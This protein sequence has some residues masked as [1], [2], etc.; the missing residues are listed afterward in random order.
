MAAA[1]IDIKPVISLASVGVSASRR[2]TAYGE[3]TVFGAQLSILFFGLG[4]SGHAYWAGESL[5]SLGFLIGNVTQKLQQAMIFKFKV[6]SR[7][8][9]FLR[10]KVYTDRDDNNYSYD[11][12][13]YDKQMKNI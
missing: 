8:Q 6:M 4:S 10:I 9:E 5:D 3:D 2:F 1:N 13:R 7:Y 12:G 11:L